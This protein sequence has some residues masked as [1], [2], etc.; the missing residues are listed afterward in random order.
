M[1]QYAIERIKI[2]STNLKNIKIENAAFED[3]ESSL[4][5]NLS[6]ISLRVV[7]LLFNDFRDIDKAIKNYKDHKEKTTIFRIKL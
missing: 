5:K 4:L 3:L 2:K 6:D 7:W 1:S